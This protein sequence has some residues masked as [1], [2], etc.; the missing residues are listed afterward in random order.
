VAARAREPVK[1]LAQLVPSV[2]VTPLSVEIQTAPSATVRFSMMFEPS[3]LVF[4]VTCTCQLT[5]SKRASPF[6]VPAQ[7]WVPKLT[8]AVMWSWGRPCCVVKRST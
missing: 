2:R 5:P 6:L 8:R 4:L 1:M 7:T 3:A